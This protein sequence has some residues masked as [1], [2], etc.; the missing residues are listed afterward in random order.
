M[1][2]QKKLD[3]NLINAVEKISGPNFWVTETAF[4][5]DNQIVNKNSYFAF[6]NVNIAKAGYT[7]LAVA[8]IRIKNATNAGINNTYCNLHSFELINNNLTIIGRNNNMEDN[9]KIQI[10]V[11]ILYKKNSL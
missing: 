5:A 11:Q 3:T 9:A 8:S 6:E 7:P 10:T 4:S 1:L 2:N